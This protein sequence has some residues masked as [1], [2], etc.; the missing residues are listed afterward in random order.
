MLLRDI[1]FKSPQENILFDDV[2]LYLAEK[3]EGA[4]IL[5]LWESKR[6]FVVLGRVSKM[7]DDVRLDQVKKDNIPILRRSSGGGTV[8]QGSGCLNYS[9]ILS[10]EKTP[11]IADLHNS[12][13]Y[14]LRKMIRVLKKLDINAVF[15]PI[16]DIAIKETKKKVSGNAQK[17]QRKFILHH[18]TLLCHFNLE[19]IGK[20]LKIPKN[21]PHYRENRDHLDFVDNLFLDIKDVKR[22]IIDVFKP[23]KEMKSINSIEKECL[24]QFLSSKNIMISN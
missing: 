6:T 19:N 5:R 10:K 11:N 14:I 13:V 24:S 9:L 22:S 4:E 18:G 7:E 12:Y 2:L 23:N 15:Y 8:L 17:R 3:R 1:S 20:Y 16:S 21:I